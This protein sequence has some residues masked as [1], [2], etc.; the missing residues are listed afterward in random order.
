MLFPISSHIIN[1]LNYFLAI[2]GLASNVKID[3]SILLFNIPIHLMP[4]GL[5]ESLWIP[6][7]F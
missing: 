4:Y 5:G 2:I 1:Y 3:R 7:L 6:Y